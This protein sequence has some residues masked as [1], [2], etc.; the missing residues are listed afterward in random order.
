MLRGAVAF[1]G[2]TAVTAQLEQGRLWRLDQ[3]AIR[4][5]AAR[6]RPAAVRAARAVSTLAE[7]VPI[8]AVL[9]LF[10]AGAVRRAGWRGTWQPFLVVAAGAAARRR[11]SRV[12]A[13]PRPPA[14][15]WLAVPEGFSLPSKHTTLAALAA[16][17][18]ARSAGMWPACTPGLAAG[19]CRGRHEPG[20]PGRPLA[21]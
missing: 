5:V 1:A 20:L 10:A 9:A 3:A 8:S 21:K 16:G 15:I 7:P 19:G 13:R 18:C 4:A 11:L 12:I 6:R 17:A 14:A 2:L